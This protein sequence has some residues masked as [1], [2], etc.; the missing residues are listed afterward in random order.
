MDI[1]IIV[2]RQYGIVNIYYKTQEQAK[3]YLT[4]LQSLYTDQWRIVCC[5]STPDWEGE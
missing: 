2:G 4:I 1:Y 3:A 5:H